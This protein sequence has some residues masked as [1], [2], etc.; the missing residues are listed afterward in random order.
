MISTEFIAIWEKRH[1]HSICNKADVDKAKTL[2]KMKYI[3]FTY[4]YL[5]SYN[6]RYIIFLNP[7]TSTE[8]LLFITKV[9]KFQN[10]LNNNK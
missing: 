2:L 9:E 4:K 6:I 8:N 5:P 10:N 3:R 1:K 7:Q